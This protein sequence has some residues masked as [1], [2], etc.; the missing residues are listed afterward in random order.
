M[1]FL[2]VLG[3]LMDNFTK[4]CCNICTDSVIILRVGGQGKY[5]FKRFFYYVIPLQKPIMLSW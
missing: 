1:L 3:G 4:T 5:M 2:S